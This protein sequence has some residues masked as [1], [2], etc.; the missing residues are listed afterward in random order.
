MYKIKDFDMLFNLCPSMEYLQV[1]YLSDIDIQV[2]LH[3]DYLRSLCFHALIR[4]DDNDNGDEMMKKLEKTI[5]S[6]KPR[7]NYTIKRIVDHIYLEWN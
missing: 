3:N 6:K 1:D 5:N 7:M 4:D 2:F